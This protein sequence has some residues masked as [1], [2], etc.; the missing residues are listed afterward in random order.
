[1]RK[2]EDSDDISS[3]VKSTTPSK[4]RKRRKRSAWASGVIKKSKRNS[5]SKKIDTSHNEE[6]NEDENETATEDENADESE[7]CAMVIFPSYRDIC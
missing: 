2:V 6:E 4:T 3:F 7:R 1:M 5:N